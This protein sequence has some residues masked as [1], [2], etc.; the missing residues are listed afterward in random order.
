M[1]KTMKKALVAAMALTMCA[2]TSIGVFASSESV[3]DRAPFSSTVYRAEQYFAKK[4][5]S[6]K[7]N[8]AADAF[9][10]KVEN[11][12]KMYIIDVRS[13]EDF[14]KGHVKN[15]VNIPY[16]ADIAENLERIP[17]NQKVYVYCYS[18]QTASQVMAILRMVGVDAYNVSG[19]YNNGISK[20]AKAVGLITTD[21][22]RKIG[23]HKQDITDSFEAAV[24]DYFANA[25]G[26]YNIS[27]T[28][29]QGKILDGSLYLLDIRAEADHKA[30]YIE[31]VDMNIPYG[32]GMQEEFS[33]L[34]KDKKIIVQC[35]SGQTASQAVATLRLMGYDAWNL[36]GGTNGWTAANLPLVK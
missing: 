36:S 23:N 13:A 26:K 5:A 10:T 1:N 4:I 20:S 12:D 11:R 29:A 35:Y 18:G 24:A 32:T 3:D 8:V 33:K 30:G 34:P 9:L 27:N 2:S 16:G 21:A 19:G 28:E 22:G 7:N 17:T 14:A 31:G 25:V 6:G 15:A